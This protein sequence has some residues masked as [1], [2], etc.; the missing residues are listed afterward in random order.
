MIA[1]RPYMRRDHSGM[2]WS[3]TIVILVLNVLFFYLKY[4]DGVRSQWA[5]LNYGA[6]SLEGIRQGYIWQLITYQFL[7]GGLMHL[8][9]NGFVLYSFG[10]PLEEAL[11][12]VAFLKLYLLSGLAGGILHLL[13]ALWFPG[14]GGPVVG[15]SAGICGLLAAF[16]LMSPH[17]VIYLFLVLPLKARYFLPLMIVVSVGFL[18]AG[19]A[20][21][22]VAHA[23]HLG[24]TLFG[25]GYYWWMQRG[26]SL[27]ALWRRWIPSRRSRPIVK[28]RFPK[29]TASWKAGDASPR[30]LAEGDFIS[31]EVDPI[32]DKIREQGI[33]SLT[34]HERDVLEKARTRMEQK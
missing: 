31:K 1:D 20:N 6:L 11:G 12:K 22:G 33:Q 5:F 7:H 18:V 29:A 27:G 28:V 15:A 14:L 32:L 24:G 2:K 34:Q 13:L 25:A 4:V 23:A 3:P 10:R 17:S 26:E 30:G 8:L 21:G 19:P 16:A 9:L